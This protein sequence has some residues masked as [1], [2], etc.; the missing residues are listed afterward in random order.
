MRSCFFSEN[1]SLTYCIVQGYN[2]LNNYIVGRINTTTRTLSY[3]TQ[4]TILST[5]QKGFL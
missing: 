5:R 1:L 4:H 3:H 2:F